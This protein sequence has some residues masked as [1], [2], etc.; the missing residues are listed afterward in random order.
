[1]VSRP[2]LA[3]LGGEAVD[4]RSV[5]VVETLSVWRIVREKRLRSVVLVLPVKTP[6]FRKTGRPAR[7][8]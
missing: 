2:S 1:M 8:V 5:T 3:D 6:K 7:T 4:V